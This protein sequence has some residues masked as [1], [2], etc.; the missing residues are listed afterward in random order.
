M[1]V[2]QSHQDQLVVTFKQ[3]DSFV[4]SARD[5]YLFQNDSQKILIRTIPT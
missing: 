4:L 1:Q 5:E 3:T 2:S